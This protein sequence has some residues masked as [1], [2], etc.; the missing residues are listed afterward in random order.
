MNTEHITGGKV[1]LAEPFMMDPYF[2]RSVV[3]LC[4][5]NTDGSLGF[6]L[7][8][9]IDMAL[10]EL[11]TDFPKFNSSV[12]YGGPVQTDTIHYIHNVGELLDDSK[13]IATGV[14]WGGD[15]EKLKL[16][17][18]SDLIQPGNIRFFVGY[19]GWSEG[20]L[21]EELNI[22]SWVLADMESNNV[23]KKEHDEL[24]QFAMNKKGDTYSII[25]QMP[26]NHFMN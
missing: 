19:S 24:W 23:F 8:K 3:L 22:G 18:S 26:D 12:Y 1:L 15:F 13:E 2:R 16:L 21:G 6:I 4:E 11:I 20:Q 9:Q 7:N 25:A 14:F 5:H 17:V 10:N